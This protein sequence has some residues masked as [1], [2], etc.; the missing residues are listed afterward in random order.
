[1]EN[2]TEVVDSLIL[3][4]RSL[5]VG[6]GTA[7][8]VVSALGESFEIAGDNSEFAEEVTEYLSATTETSGAT[9][10]RIQRILRAETGIDAIDTTVRE[11][12]P[13]AST[14]YYSSVLPRVRDLTRAMTGFESEAELYQMVATET[15]ASS[16]ATV[17][18]Y[19]RLSRWVARHP[20]A[21]LKTALGVGLG[22]T[23]LVE[24]KRIQRRETG[25]FRYDATGRREKIA[26]RSCQDGGGRTRADFKAVAGK[27]QPRHHP[28]DGISWNC[29]YD[30]A[31]LVQ[32]DVSRVLTNGCKGICDPLAYET[33]YPY[34]E[35]YGPPPDGFKNAASHY[36]CEYGTF[37]R[38]VS[39]ELGEGVHEVVAG[40]GESHLLDDALDTLMAFV[41]ILVMMLLVVGLG[42][43]MIS[44][45]SSSSS[46]SSSPPARR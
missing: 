37:V 17:S 42:S 38:A 40:L 24:L 46:T 2:A 35:G 7:V 21:V 19:R 33:L 16:E 29:G 3:A 20:S 31:H 8:D 23:F 13:T 36:V 22:T 41:V 25:C 26:E 6:D 10:E 45:L 15:D 5:E 12:L 18:L 1:M 44:A 27:L 39:K 11:T 32:Y 30:V 34:A 43:R 9:L 28:L 4:R 14:T